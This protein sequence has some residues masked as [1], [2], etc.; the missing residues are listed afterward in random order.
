M[1]KLFLDKVKKSINKA[2]TISFDIFDT[3]LIRPYTNPA[4]VFSHMEKVFDCPGFAT[5]RIDAWRRV[6]A[7]HPERE[8]WTFDMIY[9]EIDANF[10]DMKQKELDWEKKIL[11]ANPEMKPV[12]DYAVAKGKKIIIVSDMY[13]SADFL[14]K[15]LRKNGYDG[16]A[17]LYVSSEENKRKRTGSLYKLVIENNRKPGEILHI[18]DAKREDGEQPKKLGIKTVLYKQVFAQFCENNKAIAKYNSQTTT[19]GASIIKA[20]LA[21]HWMEKRVAKEE[22]SY[23]Q[24]LGYK[25]CGP[26]AYGFARF[27]ERSAK[28]NNLNHLLF[29]ARDGYILQKVFNTFNTTIKNDYVYAPRIVSYKCLGDYDGFSTMV[30]EVILRDFAEQ[31]DKIKSDVDCM[32]KNATPADWQ[33]L[34]EKHRTK[35]QQIADAHLADYKKYLKTIIKKNDRIACVDSSAAYWSAQRLLEK[36]LEKAVMGMYFV[37]VYADSK[38]AKQETFTTFSQEFLPLSK[39]FRTNPE[40][41]TKNWYMMEFLLSSPEGSIHNVASDGTPEYKSSD[42]DFE[43][44]RS[45]IYTEMLKGALRFANDVNKRF[46]GNNPF[47]G[48]TDIIRHINSLIDKPSV[49]DVKAF[50]NVNF[51]WYPTNNDKSIPLF[52]A[53]IRAKDYIFHPSRAKK[54]LKSLTWKTPFQKFYLKKIGVYKEKSETKQ[55]KK[56]FGITLYYKKKTP[57]CEEKKTCFGLIKKI[58]DK[59]YKKIYL[60]GLRVVKKKCSAW[61]LTPE[62][63]QQLKR[64]IVDSISVHTQRAMSVAFLHQRTFGEFRNKHNGQTVALVGAGPSVKYMEPIKDAIYV[65]LNRAF[66]MDKVHFDY[67]FS[68][69]K[70]GLDTGKEQFYDG[71]LNYDCIKFMGDQNMGP[72]FQ[73]PQDVMYRDAKIRRYKTTIRYLPGIFALDLETEALANSSSCSIQAMQFILFTNPKKVYVYGIDCSCASGQHFTGGAVNNAARGENAASIDAQHIG[74]WKRLKVFINTYYPNT[75]VF[76]VNPVGLRGIF[77]DVYTRSYLEAH[78]EIDATKVIIL[79]QDVDN[80][81]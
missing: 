1:K 22:T 11:F 44:N 29:I 37:V 68:I 36:A 61:A 14:A 66:L 19:I 18:G 57:D 52:S 46:D 81:K 6:I 15:V 58:K 70:A 59:K 54:M 28:E 41:F 78:P 45:E 50:Q 40:L 74:D 79:D 34:F 8:E 43:K 63:M 73:I 13:F 7:K 67:L 71:F 76:V 60:C 31:D 49:T 69:D 24:E 4:D 72:N 64:E 27:I 56:F 17:E 12:F 80:T 16:W 21:A 55:V 32:I 30:A 35:V 47:I 77:N 39:H 75:E 10:R 9:D 25:Y 42:D 53:R 5:E 3:L 51:K 62:Y 23:W 65:G 20:T 26:F 38:V 2:K 48:Y 33:A